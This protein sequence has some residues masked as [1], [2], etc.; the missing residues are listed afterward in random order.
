MKQFVVVFF[1][2][3][4]FFL[5]RLAGPSCPRGDLGD[6][7]AGGGLEAVPSSRA[8]GV[9]AVTAGLG[10]LGLMSLPGGLLPLTLAL[11]LALVGLVWLG[12]GDSGD[13]RLVLRFEGGDG[14]VEGD[15]GDLR[16]FGDDGDRH[17][18][19]GQVH[20]VGRLKNVF[21][22]GCCKIHVTDVTSHIYRELHGP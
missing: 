1:K 3:F 15:G 20:P 14:F 19:G 17:G 10:R 21:I 6:P 5:A 22:R 13:L 18:L 16:G 2:I 12:G 9:V 4:L 11:A 8:M 7:G